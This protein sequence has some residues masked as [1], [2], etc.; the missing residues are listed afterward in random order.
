MFD[1]RRSTYLRRDDAFSACENSSLILH[2]ILAT[3]ILVNRRCIIIT[4]IYIQLVTLW[5]YFPSKH[6]KFV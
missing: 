4:V 6:I 1:Q 3:Q 2:V 5:W